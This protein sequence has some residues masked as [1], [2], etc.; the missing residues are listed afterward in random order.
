M[1]K[2]EGGGGAAAS[3]SVTATGGGGGGA[4]AAVGGGVS[5]VAPC[6][7]C[8]KPSKRG[9]KQKNGRVKAKGDGVWTSVDGKWVNRPVGSIDNL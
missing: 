6:A 8:G 4:A 2:N 3:E 7:P 9:R 5:T 1:E